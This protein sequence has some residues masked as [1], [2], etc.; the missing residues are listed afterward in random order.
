MADCSRL[1]DEELES[2]V[3]NYLTEIPEPGVE[4]L[5][6]DF[7]EIDLSQLDVGD[8]DSNSC[9]NELP[10]CNNH[11]ENESSQYSTD[12]EL[13]QIIDS[14][15]EALLEA[16]TKTLDDIQEDD[17]SFSAFISSGD[18]DLCPLP[19]HLSKP[20][21]PAESPKSPENEDKLS[22]VESPM[23]RQ[24]G[25][26]PAQ[27]KTRTELH[28][29][30]VSAVPQT[31]VYSSTESNRDSVKE[32]DNDSHDEQC[33][34]DCE[35]LS[36]TSTLGTQKPQ[37]TSEREK[38]AVVDLIRY[39]HTYCLP[40]KKQHSND[41]HQHCNNILKRPKL[42]SVQQISCSDQTSKVDS[43]S[44]KGSRKYKCVKPT[45][46]RSSILKEL[47]AK[48]ISGD[49]SKP[50]RL[51]QPVY[52]EFSDSCGSRLSLGRSEQRL[53]KNLKTESGTTHKTCLTIKKESRHAE[54][55][56]KFAEEPMT[57]KMS[58]KPENSIYAVRRSC[59]LNPE[60]SEWLLFEDEAFPQTDVEQAAEEE[61]LTRAVEPFYEDEQVAELE[62][63]ELLDP[64]AQE[65]SVNV[66]VIERDSCDNGTQQFH[67]LEN[68]RSSPISMTQSVSTFEKGNFE[69]GLTVEL[70]GTAGLTPPTTPPYKTTE[71][72]HYKPEINQ[73]SVG[74]G[75]LI[76]SPSTME[77]SGEHLM[78]YKK[79]TKKQPERTEL[80]AHLSRTGDI[81]A[82]CESQ[83]L[84][85][86]F[87]R[88]FGDHDYCQVKKS[89]I[90]L[91]RKVKSL[92]LPGHVERRDKPSAVTEHQKPF[93]D[94]TDRSHK[95]G[96]K[97]LKDHEIRASLT[98]HFGF[99]DDNL[100]EENN[101]VCSSPEYD[102]VFEDNDSDSSSP[103]EDSVCLTPHRT[104]IYSRMSPP[105]KSKFQ[106]CPRTRS[107]PRSSRHNSPENRKSSRAKSSE[108]TGTLSQ[109]QIQKRRE[110]AIDEGRVIY[111]RNL[112]NTISTNELKR[113]F[114]VFGE[115]TECYVLNRS[116]GDKYGFIT[117]RCSE[118]AAMSLK[119][120][121]SLRK[122]N[123]PSF[124][125]SYGGIR[126]LFWTKYNDLDS[127]AES[128]PA[129]IKSK[130][131]SMDFDSLLKEAQR[132][133]HR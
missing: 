132:S 87:S 76:S 35:S 6:L 97:P 32:E 129:L 107:S 74:S 72:D 64:R 26:P 29:H 61:K 86:P 104:K 48:D 92:D 23:D 82:N 28:R 40:A 94:K 78:M 39:M 96:S 85:R 18:R 25:L 42:E 73:D 27:S 117:Y 68:S 123:E 106:C 31:K 58:P 57:F 103:L 122:R 119:K 80:L 77:A 71:E 75:V 41:K 115:I 83:A 43:M 14:E 56:L 98:K 8:F 112:S 100:K 84:K 89:E 62:V 130:Y 15:N 1:L 113:R 10:W 30:L 109:R 55:S 17:I 11:S 3:F 47:L 90:G 125:L 49:V 126:H 120:G 118:D 59:R 133:L 91:Q 70:C 24:A 37:F 95:T 111:I 5:L 34:D 99:P 124:H 105:S 38:R 52:A 20:S 101:R 67:P 53:V 114:E 93:E 46:V 22:I 108:K 65:N 19:G 110:K 21:F 121:A 66:D 63:G 7:S 13:F 9:F 116:K 36:I 45:P 79:Q 16:F 12:D 128:S 131:E 60:F 102:S 81:P 127:N 88:S 69:Q 51:A 54:K 2:L 50:Y 44:A 4:N 33:V